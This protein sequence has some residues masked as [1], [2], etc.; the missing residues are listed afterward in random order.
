M[1]SEF[2][3]SFSQNVA[4]DHEGHLM[5]GSFGNPDCAQCNQLMSAHAQHTQLNV[6]SFSEGTAGEP[7]DEEGHLSQGSFGDSDCP[8][9]QVEAKSIQH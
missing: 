7:R 4:R 1:S 5:E 9:C 6:G 2:E 3:G 8:I